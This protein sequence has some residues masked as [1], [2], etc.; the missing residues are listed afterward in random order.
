MAGIIYSY[1]E[2]EIIRGDQ[3]REFISFNCVN[4]RPPLKTFFEWRINKSDSDIS[5]Q[6]DIDMHSYETLFS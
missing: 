1:C 5:Y 2:D 3:L 4:M 6:P